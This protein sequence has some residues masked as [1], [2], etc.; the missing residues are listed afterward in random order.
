[1]PSVS[2]TASIEGPTANRSESARAVHNHADFVPFSSANCLTTFRFVV[3]E[4]FHRFKSVGE[5]RQPR[6]QIGKFF[7]IFINRR[8]VEIEIFRK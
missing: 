1:L 5:F 7:Q 8:L 4:I 6:L 2:K 3:R